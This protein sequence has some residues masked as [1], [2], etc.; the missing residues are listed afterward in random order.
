MCVRVRAPACFL[1]KI[2]AVTLIFHS[3]VL[4]FSRHFNYVTINFQS[5]SEHTE[6]TLADSVSSGSRCVACSSR[7]A[8][9][10]KASFSCSP[11]REGFE[12][13]LR[14]A[15]KANSRPNG[16]KPKWEV[17]QGKGIKCHVATDKK[18]GIEALSCDVN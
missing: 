18:C 14:P 13:S 9:P 1:I 12:L 6:I 5:T 3:S 15:V 2:S 8:S 10:P 11:N 4:A 7:R 17:E 16:P